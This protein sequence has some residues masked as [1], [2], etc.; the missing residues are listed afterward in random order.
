MQLDDHA[1]DVLFRHAR[2]H[3][4]FT[5]DPVDDDTL[6]RLYDLLKWGPTA[7]NSCP[8]RFVFVRS[9]AAKERLRPALAPGNVDKTM[10]APVTAIVAYDLEFYEYLPRLYPHA[11]ARSWYAGKSDEHIRSNAVR[12]G[13]LQGAYL[14]V[15]ARA[16]GLDCGPMGGFDHAKV[17]EAFFHGTKVRSN[18]LCN[19]GHGDPARLHPRNPRLE[20]GEACR[21]E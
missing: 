17:D 21:I 19:L 3:S 15:A 1:L 7:A 8:A 18:F 10:A 6:R 16:L 5:A 9:R 13:T 12:S 4:A 14:I 11:D 2:T 20:F